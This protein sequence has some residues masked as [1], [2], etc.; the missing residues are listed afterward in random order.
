MKTEESTERDGTE[1]LGSVNWKKWLG[2]LSIPIV[3][4]VVS[5]L[6]TFS[7]AQFFGEVED[8]AVLELPTVIAL[9]IAMV[10]T[11]K[12][13]YV[14]QEGEFLPGNVRISLANFLQSSLFLLVICSGVERLFMVV[15]RGNHSH[16]DLFP[17]GGRGILE[18]IRQNL[19]A[20]DFFFFLTLYGLF[21]VVEMLAFGVDGVPL[22]AK[23]RRSATLA[24]VKRNLREIDNLM[25]KFYFDYQML[26]S[27]S[28]GAIERE[29]NSEAGKPTIWSISELRKSING[30][31][32]QATF[33]FVVVQ[34]CVAV[35]T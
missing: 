31:V 30:K 33:W 25:D 14:D 26:Y 28:A 24:Q 13:I 15:E 5:I 9:V 8:S 11:Y 2:Y 19:N 1:I 35:L 16:Q 18:E 34:A 12:F 10:V 21:L 4:F 27:R 20:S 23:D 22:L 17:L 7:F 6:L 32:C 29:E 3:L